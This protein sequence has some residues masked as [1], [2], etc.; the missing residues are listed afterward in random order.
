MTLPLPASVGAW[1]PVIQGSLNDQ[2]EWPQ[3]FTFSF[4][5]SVGGIWLM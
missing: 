4:A 2:P 5:S 3:I 1:S